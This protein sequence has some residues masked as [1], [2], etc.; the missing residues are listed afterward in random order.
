[1]W[2]LIKIDNNIGNYLGLPT[3]FGI[4]KRNDLNFILDRFIRNF[5]GWKK[6]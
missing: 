6:T 1:M 2:M 4:S 3:Q 5:N